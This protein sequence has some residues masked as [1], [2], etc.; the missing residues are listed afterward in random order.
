MEFLEPMGTWHPTSSPRAQA[1]PRSASAA[2]LCAGRKQRS[3][4]IFPARLGRYFGMGEDLWA[5][6]QSRYDHLAVGRTIGR[7]AK[8]KPGHPSILFNAFLTDPL[9]Y[10]I[11]LI[12]YLWY[13]TAPGRDQSAKM[14][15]DQSAK[16]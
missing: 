7:P 14:G 10:F 11:Y 15:V 1:C 6:V 4:L 8:P 12:F 9:H 16:K 2:S 5:R 3:P 13:R